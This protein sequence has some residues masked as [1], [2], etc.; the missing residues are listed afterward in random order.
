MGEP[1]PTRDELNFLP[2][3]ISTRVRAISGGLATAAAG[4]GS[5]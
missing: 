2:D 3:L 4:C 5:T 1:M